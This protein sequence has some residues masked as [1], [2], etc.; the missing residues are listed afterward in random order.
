MVSRA[1]V[2]KYKDDFR[3]NPVGTGPF[4]FVEWVKDDISRSAGSTA[5]GS[6]TSASR[7]GRVPADPGLVVRFTAMRTGQI[8][9]MHQ[10]HPKDVAHGQGPSAG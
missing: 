9:I 2:G 8:D 10:I 3:R 6:W 7:R 1:A 5:T 4:R